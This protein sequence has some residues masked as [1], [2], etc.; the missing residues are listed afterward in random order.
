MNREAVRGLYI[1]WGIAF[2]VLALAVAGRHPYGFFVFLRWICFLVF[3]YSAWASARLRRP[4]WAW[5][6]AVEAVLFNPLAPIHMSRSLWQ[7]ADW[8]ALGGIT[9]A[10]AVFWRDLTGAKRV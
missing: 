1:G 2:V 3:G 8:L 5:A 9:G 7:A 6:F 10:A 4:V